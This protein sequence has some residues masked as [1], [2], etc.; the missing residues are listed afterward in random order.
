M[1][2]GRGARREPSAPLPSPVP[3]DGVADAVDG[4]EGGRRLGGVAQVAE[5]DRPGLGE[6]AQLGITGLEHTVA[7]QRRPPAP[8]VPARSGRAHPARPAARSERST[9]CRPVS[10]EPRTS[11]ICRPGTQVQQ[12]VLDAGREQGAAGEQEPQGRRA[13]RIDA[14]ARRPSGRANASPTMRSDEHRSRSTVSSRSSG[15]R[16]AGWSCTTTVPP[17]SHALIAF[18][19]AAPCMNGGAARARRSEVAARATS[20]SSDCVTP[21]HAT[22][23]SACRH[24]TPLGM[25]VVPPV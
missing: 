25:P 18:Q 14:A 15:S 3:S 8:W 17:A 6:P 2:R 21:R 24:S 16:C 10:D 5:G 12:L 19:W 23:K 13:D 22:R 9:P 1:T 20:W 11:T 4:G 7:S